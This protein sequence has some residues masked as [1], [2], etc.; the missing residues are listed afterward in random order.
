MKRKTLTHKSA[1]KRMKFRT[2]DRK[3]RT[4]INQITKRIERMSKTHTGEV[5]D[6]A[7]KV[8]RWLRDRLH[9]NAPA[10]TTLDIM[11]Y[12]RARFQA[13]TFDSSDQIAIGRAALSFVKRDDPDAWGKYINQVPDIQDRAAAKAES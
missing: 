7:K 6:A 12:L 3:R 11:T 4:E 10:P 1:L 8:A 5:T 9:S 2:K 13:P